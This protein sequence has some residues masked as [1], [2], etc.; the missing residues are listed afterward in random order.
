VLLGQ[1][2]TVN[3][4]SQKECI[5]IWGAESTGAT[6][7]SSDSGSWR[8]TADKIDAQKQVSSLIS[9]Y[10]SSYNQGYFTENNQGDN[11]L[12]SMI[13]DDISYA[14][15]SYTRAAVV[16]FDHGQGR[17]DYQGLNEF[18]FMF[19]DN[20]GVATGDRD[21]IIWVPDNAVYDMDVYP[22]VNL[23]KVD[24][25][26][27][28]TCGSANL[29]NLIN[30][31]SWQ[32]LIP[33]TYRARGM[34]FAW[35]GRIVN[36]GMSSYGYSSPDDGDFFWY[37]SNR[38][39]SVIDALDDSSLDHYDAPF[40]D[41]DLYGGYHAFWPLWN[42]YT[43]QWEGGEFPDSTMKVYGNGNIH[44]YRRGG[45]WHLEGNAVDSL[46]NTPGSI[47]GTAK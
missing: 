27:I 15:A 18:H 24:F 43:Q 39:N 41:T 14:E 5:E 31:Q 34:P 40:G 22:R 44:L 45:I 42:K 11:S 12:K 30:G 10:F 33:G 17:T 26:F 9:V 46:H 2:L 25:A 16:D 36:S 37:A 1:V 19:E 28:N 21:H 47:G 6:E 38:G 4:T 20:V 35:S 32:G 8:K 3:A 7:P 13:L 23:G 29:T